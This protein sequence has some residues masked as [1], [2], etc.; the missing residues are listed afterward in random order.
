MAFAEGV[1]DLHDD[2]AQPAVHAVAVPEAHRLEG[3][4]QHAWVGVQPDVAR[5]IANA[6]TLQ[7]ALQPGECAAL[8][9]TAAVAVV[10]VMEADRCRTVH[11]QCAH[12]LGIV[13]LPH[14][15]QQK[16]G[17]V[18]KR[19]PMRPQ[20]R[21]PDLAEADLR[22]RVAAHATASLDAAVCASR[23][24]A[25]ARPDLRPSSWKP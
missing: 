14:G 8:F 20:A 13:Q 21:V 17:V 11:C 15:Q 22:E 2:R 19:M 25:A 7:Q 24:S 6:F 12:G 10:A 18:G 1:V 3:V 5:G 23:A 9:R 16:K 4:A